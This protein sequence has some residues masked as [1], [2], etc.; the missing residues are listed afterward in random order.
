MRGNPDV[1]DA[2]NDILSAELTAINQY[3]IHYKMCENWGYERLAAKN[4][5][6]SMEE[7]SHA[8][9]VIGRI[10]YLEGVPNMQRLNPIRVGENVPEQHRLDLDLEREAADRLN[11][12]VALPARHHQGNRQGELPGRADALSLYS[13]IS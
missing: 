3:Y 5:E 13:V 2:L 7:M 8:D 10:L 9:K 4:R 6:E 11:H 1:I 12:C